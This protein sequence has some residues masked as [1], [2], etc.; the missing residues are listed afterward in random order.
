[1]QRARFS[2]LSL[3]PYQPQASIPEADSTPTQFSSSLPKTSPLPEQKKLPNPI[4]SNS[5]SDQNE[6]QLIPCPYDSHISY[7]R[8][9]GNNMDLMRRVY[10]TQQEMLKFTKE[11]RQDSL[12]PNLPKY[13]E[14]RQEMNDWL[15]KD[16]VPEDTKA[17]MYAQQLQRVKQLKNQVF[18][19]ES[20]PVQMITQT[21][22]TMT[23]ELHSATPSEQFN[24]TDK[25]IIDSVP[26]TMQNRAKLL[27]QKLKDHSDVISWNDHGQ[28]VLEGSIVPNSNI[29]DLVNDVMRKRKDF[30]PEHSNTFAKALAKINVPED[31]LRNP[32][33]IDSIRW[34]R[35]L[36]DSQAPG[37]SFVS[38]TVEAPTEVPRKTPKSPT[39]SALVYGKWLKAPR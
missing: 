29:I 34:Y 31:Y 2:V 24:A 21:E 23:S 4:P 36:Q 9:W 39:T 26:K 37:L 32:D 14:A 11:K 3:Q 22:R 5:T 6:D 1:M 17:T 10:L 15:E 30:N 33:R 8:I 20:S 27:I 35:R 18:R 16:D 13:Y 28:L 7:E 25:Q 12:S 38:Q 19:P